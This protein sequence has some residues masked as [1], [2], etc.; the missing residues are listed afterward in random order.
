MRGPD[1]L[2][3][4]GTNMVDLKQPSADAPYECI[5]LNVFK[6]PVSMVHSASK[7][8]ALRTFLESQK[9]D[10][11]TDDDGLPKYLVICWMFSN[12]FATEYTLVQ[13]LFRRKSSSSLNEDK[14]LATAAKRFFEADVDGKN[15][16]FK[17]MFKV[18][19]GPAV[20]TGAVSTLGGERPVLIGKKL[21]TSYFKGKNYFEIG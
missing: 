12:F 20:M 7:I 9:D 13:H 17:Y 10:E 16:Q 19:E 18:V 3:Q 11:G 4:T 21:T 15:N 2:K 1:Y 8:E 6:S 5:G 14:A